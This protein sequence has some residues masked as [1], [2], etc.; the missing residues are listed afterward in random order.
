MQLDVSQSLHS[1]CVIFCLPQTSLYLHPFYSEFTNVFSAHCEWAMDEG[2][3][4]DASVGAKVGTWGLGSLVRG[5]FYS[6]VT[7]TQ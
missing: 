3:R 1:G 2:R 6:W 4:K 5:K 7:F